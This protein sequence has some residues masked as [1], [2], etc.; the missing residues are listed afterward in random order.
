MSIDGRTHL[1]GVIGW[2]VE[3]SLSPAMHNAAYAA[4]DLNWVYLPLPVADQRHLM[5]VVEALRA[6]PFVGFNVT[7][8]HKRAMLELC[9][10][11]AMFAQLAGSVNTVHCVDGHL[12]GYNTD[13]RGMLEALRL[14]ANWSPE[15]ARVAVLGAGG[16]AGAALVACAV[17]RAAHVTVVNRDV[18]RAEELAVRAEPSFRST[19]VVAVAAGPQ[20]QEAIEAA[21][22]VVNATPVGMTSGDPSPVPEGWLRAGQVVFDMVYQRRS[23]AL[24]DAARGAGAT[25]LGGVGML[26]SQGALA[27]DIWAECTQDP[28]PRDVMR[29]AAEAALARSTEG[30]AGR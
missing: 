15:G 20:S 16:A 11:V 14:E 21:D 29:A 3:H 8:P 6:L 25:A 27:I 9:D 2:P 28:A 30:G 13:G 26:V 18:A 12:V 10:E 5:A 24:L 4:M 22:L 17:G 23:T 1:A 19:E 7:M